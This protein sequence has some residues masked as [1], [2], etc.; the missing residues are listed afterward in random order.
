MRV[1]SALRFLATIASI[2]LPWS[3]RRWV[4]GR[5]CGYQLDARSRIG[6][7]WVAPARLVLEEGAS[8]GH[9]TVCK[10][11]DL[12]YLKE[13]VE[14]E[15]VEQSALSSR[16]PLPYPADHAPAGGS[17]LGYERPVS[18]PSR[19]RSQPRLNRGG[20]GIERSTCSYPLQ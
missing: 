4:L 18:P 1:R 12:V 14:K 5:V 8:I 2:P 10:G 16:E 19:V 7:S 15:G 9:F 13:S 17:T 3:S 11:L 20:S 6:L